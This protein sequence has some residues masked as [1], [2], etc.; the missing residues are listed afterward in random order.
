M[1]LNEI[2]KVENLKTEFGIFSKDKLILKKYLTKDCIVAFEKN[3]FGS[4]FIFKG[5]NIYF[6]FFSINKII[7][8]YIY[9]GKHLWRI[10]NSKV[11]ELF[12]DKIK[13]LDEDKFS[14]VKK[15]EILK[16]LK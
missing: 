10:P 8:N 14:R 9:G 15:I 11:F 6:S 5:K 4:V 12:S 2:L 13:I 1:K 3:T 7:G 16:N